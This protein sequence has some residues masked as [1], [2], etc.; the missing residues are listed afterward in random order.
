[1]Q[2]SN[3][4]RV[5]EH[6]CGALILD[7]G[8]GKFFSVD[9][10]G[11]LIVRWLQENVEEGTLLKRLKNT[12]PEKSDEDLRDDLNGFLQMLTFKSLLA[13]SECAAT[14]PE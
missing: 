5:T 1:M 8:R 4:V 9:P 3:T 12:F 13:A 10:V 11:K 7:V 6:D 14:V 2:L